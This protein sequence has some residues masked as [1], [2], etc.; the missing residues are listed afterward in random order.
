MTLPPNIY[1]SSSSGG[2]G[3][4]LQVFSEALYWN[5]NYIIG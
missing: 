2:Y 1:I 5:G 3:G 4:V